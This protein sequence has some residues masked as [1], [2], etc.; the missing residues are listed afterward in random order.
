MGT[1]GI[2]PGGAADDSP[3]DYSYDM[4]HDAAAEPGEHH[5][6][7]VG[8]PGPRAPEPR[9]WELDGDYSYDLAHEVPPPTR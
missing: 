4:A 6:P 5:V 7:Q 1:Q 2:P 8:G 9:P 3:G